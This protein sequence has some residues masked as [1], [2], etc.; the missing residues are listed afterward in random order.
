MELLAAWRS[1]LYSA[2]SSSGS[3]GGDPINDIASSLPS[4]QIV[5]FTGVN[6]SVGFFFELVSLTLL[7]SY[8]SYICEVIGWPKC[9][10]HLTMWLVLTY[11]IGLVLILEFLP[12]GP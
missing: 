7:A 5:V 11:V 10:S 6:G 1:F 12:R 2:G 4:L 3:S 8:R 9:T